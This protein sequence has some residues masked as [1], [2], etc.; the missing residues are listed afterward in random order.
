MR[1]MREMRD[2]TRMPQV[3]YP[4]TDTRQIGRI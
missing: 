2:E 4:V 1:E 3:V